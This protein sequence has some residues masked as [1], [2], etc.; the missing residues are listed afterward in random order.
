MAN[1]IEVSIEMIFHA[2]ENTKKIFEPIFDLFQIKE[3]EFSEEK[4][5]GHYGNPILLFKTILEKKRG[6]EF[7]QSLVSKISQAQIDEVLDNIDMYF[8]DSSLFLRIGKGEIVNKI[9]N[10]QQN[11]AIKIK[12][13]VPI[14]KKDDIVRT[15]TELLRA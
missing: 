8:E 12:I 7:V 9:I 14:Y 4:I 5:V 2:T 3:E 1:K 6:A 15:Y 11:N 10:L 13:K